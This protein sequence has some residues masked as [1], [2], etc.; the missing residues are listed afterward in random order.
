MKFEIISQKILKSVIFP[1]QDDKKQ[2]LNNLETSD[3]ESVRR[4]SGR[5]APKVGISSSL[6]TKA[7]SSYSIPPRI[8]R[9][10]FYLL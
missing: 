10:T 6:Y 2:S 8:L 4:K 7:S 1:Q 9:K 5:V 3:V